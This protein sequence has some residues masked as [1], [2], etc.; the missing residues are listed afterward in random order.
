MPPVTR[1]LNTYCARGGILRGPS[2]IDDR[3]ELGLAF[4]Y[5]LHAEGGR[6]DVADLVE[7]ARPRGALVVD[8]LAVGEEL[9]AVRV[10]V[11]D[12]PGRVRD[13]AEIVLDHRS[14]H[15]ALAGGQG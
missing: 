4:S 6:E 7:V 14:R 13:R 10:G 11:D 3:H 5:L 15:L 2:G 12:R 1:P 8:L 9:G